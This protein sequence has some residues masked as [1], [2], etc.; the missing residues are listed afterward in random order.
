[1]PHGPRFQKLADEAKAKIREVTPGE[2]RKEQKAGAV[3]MDVREKEEWDKERA[4][5]A[6]HLSKGIL[7]VK[8]EEQVPELLAFDQGSLDYIALLEDS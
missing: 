7:E 3:L 8:I 5:G 4:A 1:M 2:A 6:V